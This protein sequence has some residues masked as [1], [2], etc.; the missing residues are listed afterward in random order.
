MIDTLQHAPYAA[1]Y[2]F[3]LSS[4]VVATFG[5]IS[6]IVILLACLHN[7]ICPSFNETLRERLYNWLVFITVG[8]AL[9]N[10]VSER[11]PHALITTFVGIQAIFM[12]WRVI[13]KRFFC[14]RK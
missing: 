3:A 13:E 12:A 4:P 11:L 8:A 14:K 5:L 1:I 6:L 2:S 10:I 9:M 7:I